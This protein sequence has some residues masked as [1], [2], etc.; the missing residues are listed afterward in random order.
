MTIT[1]NPNYASRMNERRPFHLNVATNP[2]QPRDD[3]TPKTAVRKT[4]IRKTPVKSTPDASPV[5][6]FVVRYV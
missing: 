5:A 6:E 1:N 3:E 2:N 4:P